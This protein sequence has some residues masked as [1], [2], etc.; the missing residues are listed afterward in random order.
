METR[1]KN[2]SLVF[3]K[4][5]DILV[6]ETRFDRRNVII[7]ISLIRVT[8]SSSRRIFH[9]SRVCFLTRK[10]KRKEARK[11]VD[12]G[13]KK[14]RSNRHRAKL[15]VK[16]QLHCFTISTPATKLI[17]RATVP[18]STINFSFYSPPRCR[19]I[20]FEQEEDSFDSLLEFVLSREIVSK[21]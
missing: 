14:K 6:N 16:W 19:L 11:K 4:L 21:L 8:S 12:E 9:K 1:L 15:L 20:N 17:G 7:R 10:K 3:S 2:E 5:H 18:T 13:G